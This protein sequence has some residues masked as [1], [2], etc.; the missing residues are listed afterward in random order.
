MS[1]HRNFHGWACWAC[2][3][4]T[5]HQIRGPGN[6][7]AAKRKRGCFAHCS[8]ASIYQARAPRHLWRGLSRSPRPLLVELRSA[9][10]SGRGDA[11][12]W[13]RPK[14]TSPDW[15]PKANGC[16]VRAVD[17]ELFPCRAGTHRRVIWCA[18]RV[19]GVEL[20]VTYWYAMATSPLPD[21]E[22]TAQCNGGSIHFFNGR[23]ARSAP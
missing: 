14:R 5:R 2:A 9:R 12:A 13:R 21:P 15:P 10:T 17:R 23:P 7:V 19:W 1:T 16:R 20:P 8:H 22:A 6:P 11:N 4:R 3:T 18:S